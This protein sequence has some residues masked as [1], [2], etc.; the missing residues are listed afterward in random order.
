MADT[1]VEVAETT[2]GEHK[3]VQKERAL[4]AAASKSA[5]KAKALARARQL[6]DDAD[7]AMRFYRGLYGDEDDAVRNPSGASSSMIPRDEHGREVERPRRRR[8]ETPVPPERTPRSRSPRTKKEKKT[9]ES[10]ED[11][12]LLSR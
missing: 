11:S 10:H 2:Y 7:T 9:K 3:A 6:R 12:Q 4:S 5:A 1:N 8:E